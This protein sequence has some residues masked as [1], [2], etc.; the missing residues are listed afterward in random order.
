M[1]PLAFTE[2][3]VNANAETMLTLVPRTQKQ[4]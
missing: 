3:A 4:P 2:A 1:V